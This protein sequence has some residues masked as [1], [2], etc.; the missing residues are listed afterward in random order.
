M[1]RIPRAIGVLT[2]APFRAYGGEVPHELSDH[3]EHHGHHHAAPSKELLDG[4]EELKKF[5]ATLPP[6]N[7]D[8]VVNEYLERCK[9]GIL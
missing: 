3:A 7:Y 5:L 6:R 4:I 2:K 1:L 8:P 9:K